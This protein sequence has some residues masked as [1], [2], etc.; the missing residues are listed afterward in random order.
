MIKIPRF[1]RVA[2][3]VVFL[4]SL[5]TG[6]LACGDN[7]KTYISYSASLDGK[8]WTGPVNYTLTDGKSTLYTGTQVN[9]GYSASRG[10]FVSTYVSGGPPG[11]VFKGIGMH[12]STKNGETT[13]W[14]G[15]VEE[16]GHGFTV[17]PPLNMC[18]SNPIYQMFY[19]F[20]F[21][22]EVTIQVNVTLDGKD[23]SGAVSYT[24][25]SP[26]Q[27]TGTFPT[28]QVL[29]SPKGTSA[30]QQFLKLPAGEYSIT[31]ITGG[32][33]DANFIGINPLGN[34]NVASLN[35][36]VFTLLYRSKNAPENPVSVIPPAPATT[37]PASNQL[38]VSA[39]L[40]GSPWQGALSFTISGTQ[41]L[42]GTSV[43][44]SFTGL[45]DGAYYASYV[46]GGPP[47]AELKKTSVLGTNIVGGR[48]GILTFDFVSKGSLT[49]NGFI[50][51][52]PWFGNCRYA[53]DGPVH[54]TGSNVTSTFKDVPLGQ[55]TLT[56]ISG[57]PEGYGFDGLMPQTLKLTA[58]AA[59]GNYKI[60]FNLP[61]SGIVAAA[62]AD[63]G[64]TVSVNNAVPLSASNVIYTITVNNAGP[65][66]T[67][68]VTVSFPKGLLTY[69]SDTGAG[70][71]I[72]ATGVW[73]IGNMASNATAT[74]SVTLN[75]GAWTVGSTFTHTAMVT[76]SSVTDPVASNNSG[77][78]TIVIH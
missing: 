41:A 46:S 26:S 76:A 15:S 63:L 33:P 42:S 23:W 36:G 38:N 7:L 14:D 30:P 77:S 58:D 9:G 16:A 71:Y 65:L 45:K 43:A 74:L 17:D 78:A 32:P 29:P 55:Y 51:N 73:T 75:T 61:P 6:A 19:T 40:D 69:V 1:L 48:T 34:L 64:V 3:I 18:D 39:T 4:L 57:G 66:A 24:L 59:N 50:G 60:F 70:S 62:G 25:K 47:N 27:I 2:A 68:G 53:I 22:T 56:Y 21:V 67:T 37:A 49:V 52:S 28:Q 44:Q 13:T 54:L 10:S 35:T 72:S 5:F 12:T 11:S 20:R 31:D 8:P